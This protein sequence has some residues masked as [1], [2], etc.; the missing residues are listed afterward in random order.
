MVVAEDPA[1]T[2]IFYDYASQCI[3]GRRPPGMTSGAEALGGDPRGQWWAALCHLEEAAVLAF[4]HLA[5]ELRAL[6]APEALCQA[7]LDAMR[8]EI[9][10]VHLTRHMA[11]RHGVEPPR[12]EAAAL[13]TR[14]LWQL[15]QDNAVEGC[16]RE[17]FA[18]LETGWQ[19][20]RADD[21]EARAILAQISLDETRHGQLSWQ[22]HAFAQARLDPEQRARLVNLQRE[23]IDDLGRA[24]AARPADATAA[25][26]GLPDASQHA[27]LVDAF[28]EA[29]AA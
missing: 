14:T 24:G 16:V 7:A 1:L 13:P 25:A 2:C 11:R 18:A 19:A 21:P 9:L 4:A 23:A 26:L 3:G 22:I 28:T 27:A 5:A 10:H 29:L 12:A 15:A 6:G 17:A 20:Q 8:D